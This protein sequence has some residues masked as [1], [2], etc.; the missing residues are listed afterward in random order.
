MK[1]FEKNLVK[2]WEQVGK[3]LRGIEKFCEK[4]VRTLRENL[5]N[6]K[7]NSMKFWKKIGETL[8]VNFDEIL[9]KMWWNFEKKFVKF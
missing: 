5:W 9:K 4:F 2:F 1:N 7:K 8:D 6:F 3:I